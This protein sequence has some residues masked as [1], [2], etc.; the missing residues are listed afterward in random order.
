MNDA[1]HWAG[2]FVQLMQELSSAKDEMARLQLAVDS[3]VRLVDRCSHAGYTINEKNG[4]TTRLGSD[5]I[6]KRANE[7]QFEI[8]EG[9]CIS[10]N[11]QQ[12]TLI[13]RELDRERRYPTW[14]S[15][16]HA[17]L[18][19]GSMMSILVYHDDHSYG[20]LSFYTD[21]GE[22][23]DAD[24][25]AVAEAISAHLAVV[26]TS[27]REIDHLGMALR[28]RLAIGRAEGIIMERLDL[29]AERAFDYLRRVSSHTNRKLVA[30]ATEIAETRQLPTY[31]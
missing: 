23:F 14:A 10:V 30:V 5:E 2:E 22:T 13:C 27:G 26:M 3:A 18:G 16:V 1:K 15:R 4:I 21:I 28:N 11:R 17:E 31:E 19:V 25:V 7:L 24:D 9:P 29:T 8:G 20:C 12:V 6:V